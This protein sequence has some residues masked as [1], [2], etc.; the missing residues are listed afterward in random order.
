MRADA[1]LRRRARQVPLIG[2]A[3]GEVA[4]IVR[5]RSFPGSQHYWERRYAHGGDSGDGS[6]GALATFKAGI[7]NDLVATQEIDSVIEFGCGDGNQ[8]SLAHYP[9]YLGLDVSTSVLRRSMR[10]FAEDRTKSFLHYDPI[11]FADPAGY[12]RAQL[13]LSLDVLYHLVEDKIYELHL[14][15]L[16][17]SAQRFVV[18]YTSDADTISAAG[19]AAAHICHRPVARDVATRFPHWSLAKRVPNPY[20]VGP[21]T[22]CA[23]FFIY[24]R[25]HPGLIQPSCRSVR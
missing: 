6:R 16:F 9:R 11:S 21:V 2:T 15:H 20:R 24:R 18:L 25:E 13:A 4:D 1:A 8:L 14:R 22:S 23:E 7:V 17:G 12:L 5:R 3:L 10:R 19:Q